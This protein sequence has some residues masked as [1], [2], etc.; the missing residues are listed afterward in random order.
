ME[1][2]RSYRY[3]RKFLVEE[4]EVGQVRT[5]IR[6]HPAMFYEQYPVRVV[7]NLYLDTEE[8]DLYHANQNGTPERCKVRLRWYGDVLGQIASPVL[9]FKIKDGNVGTKKSYPFPTF[10]LEKGFSR[11]EFQGL[12][13]VAEV[14]NQVH[15]H[16]RTLNVVLCNSYKRWYYASRDHCYRL[17][18]D[19]DMTYYPIHLFNNQF[20]GCARDH[21]YVIVELKY[22]KAYEPKAG[23]IANLLPFRVTRNSKYV[24]GMESV[25]L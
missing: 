25:Y 22:E 18:V 15:Q 14:P 7:N 3:E 12:A 20:L 17:T 10:N 16:L 5:V 2:A 24:T 13:R 21:G 1:E 6:R 9:E 11:D 4:L 8:L 19:V 23:R